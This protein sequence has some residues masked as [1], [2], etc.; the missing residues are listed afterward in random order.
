MAAENL[1]IIAREGLIDRASQMGGMLASA[2]D[3]LA[4]HS[5]VGEIRRLGL[6]IGVEIVK[7]R[8]QR[9]HYPLEA[10]VCA[11]VANEALMRGVIV[12]ATGN[13]LV[14]TPPFI[15]AEEEI[16]MIAGA[17]GEALDAVAA[18]LS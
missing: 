5:L 3:P 2:L 10:A 9:L 15:I 6:I 14:I 18:T 1:A 17:L 11:R 12:R 4:G 8:E 16:A 7:D 13:S